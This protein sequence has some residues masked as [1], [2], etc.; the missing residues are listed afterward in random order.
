MG[1]QE[2]LHLQPDHREDGDSRVLRRQPL[3]GRQKVLLA[4]DWRRLHHDLR[5]DFGETKLQAVIIL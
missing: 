1:G 5:L 2:A 3:P 4:E